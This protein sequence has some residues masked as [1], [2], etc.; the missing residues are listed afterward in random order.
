MPHVNTVNLRMAKNKRTNSTM[1]D[2]ERQVLDTYNDGRTLP[3][4]DL[5]GEP[6]V[7]SPAERVRKLQEPEVIVPRETD[8]SQEVAFI[9]ERVLSN[10][11]I[12]LDTLA[13]SADE[14]LTLS[15]E[16]M[17]IIISYDNDPQNKISAV[18]AL[19]GIANNL[20]ARK[21]IKSETKQRVHVTVSNAMTVPR[22]GQR[23]LGSQTDE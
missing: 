20:L 12:D 6:E 1:A 18:K 4:I 11:D 2:F 17:K 22:K 14:G 13:K 21:R 23:S 10:A 9:V 15:L 19:T 3:P 7:L 5:D 8:I 16:K